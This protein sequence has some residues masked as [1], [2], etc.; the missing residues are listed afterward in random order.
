MRF[1][2]HIV[3]HRTE[4]QHFANHSLSISILNAP[5]LIC[6]HLGSVLNG[7]P[8]QILLCDITSVIIPVNF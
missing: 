7:Q 6:Y 4:L 3:V 1:L 2:M 8:S 5:I